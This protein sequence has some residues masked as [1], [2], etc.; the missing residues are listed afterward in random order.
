MTN[1]A[2]GSITKMQNCFSRIDSQRGTPSRVSRA[3]PHNRLEL[4]NARSS[5]TTHCPDFDAR[6]HQAERT[7]ERE[8]AECIARSRKKVASEFRSRWESCEPAA[9]ISRE[10]A[11]E[12]GHLSDPPQ[13]Q[14]RVSRP[15]L[16]QKWMNRM[17]T[18]AG[19]YIKA[20]G[21]SGG[22][23]DQR[24]VVQR[25][26][27][28]SVVQVALSEAR[29][30]AFV[31]I[32]ALEGLLAVAGLGS[33]CATRSAGIGSDAR[34]IS[35]SMVHDTSAV[36]PAI[37]DPEEIT[38]KPCSPG[39]TE[40]SA[41]APSAGCK[42]GNLKILHQVPERNSFVSSSAENAASAHSEMG[43]TM[44]SDY[45]TGADLCVRLG[46]LPAVLGG[47]NQH[48]GHKQIELLAISLLYA[49]ATDLSA[50]KAL[51]GNHGVAAAC[52]KRMFP[53]PLICDAASSRGGG[54]T[55]VDVSHAHRD[56][57]K[58]TDDALSTSHHRDDDVEAMVADLSG[59]TSS[60]PSTQ[61]R[62]E[63]PMV[64]PRS[65]LVCILSVALRSSP[66]CQR[67][68]LQEKGVEAMLSTIRRT[69][70][71]SRSAESA[72]LTEAC[73]NV[74]EYLGGL[75]QGRRRLV[76][77]DAVETTVSVIENFR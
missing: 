69:R 28:R 68:V 26:H 49:F 24:L 30:N 46:A 21:G 54:H 41:K 53:M 44:V 62:K 39:R 23:Q 66:E 59:S 55:T 16:R 45:C 56:A 74:L 4:N 17:A 75:K 61:E 1:L 70:V 64:L 52:V 42:R 9:T 35:T 27:V 67:I 58:C 73:L 29:V 38:G 5:F 12:Q 6:M 19:A 71:G 76:A 50:C 48:T 43:A 65:E 3:V 33:K 37:S 47:L 72:R 7:H 8:K 18:T 57:T 60:G 13:I 40:K 2:G 32:S 25:D 77:E 10:T 14:Y 63:L 51:R 15:F 31:I 34:R 22:C 20:N 11:V 36:P